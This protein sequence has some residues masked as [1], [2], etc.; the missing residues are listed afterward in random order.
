MANVVE[1]G[2]G[3]PANKAGK[4]FLSKAVGT[5]G[6]AFKSK[7]SASRQQYAKEV[8]GRNT[9]RDEFDRGVVASIGKSLEAGELTWAGEAGKSD[10]VTPGQKARLDAA[11]SDKKKYSKTL[12]AIRA[13]ANKDRDKL[14]KLGGS[15]NP[16]KVLGKGK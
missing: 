8:S 3:G 16:E 15:R 2:S 12:S 9:R 10:I 1:E 11:G 14:Q 4:S 7:K 6:K 5:I 13:E